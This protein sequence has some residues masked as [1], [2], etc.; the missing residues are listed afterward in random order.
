MKNVFPMSFYS[1]LEYVSNI[2]DYTCR[3]DIR[4]LATNSLARPVE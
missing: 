1:L 2:L 4:E 3:E